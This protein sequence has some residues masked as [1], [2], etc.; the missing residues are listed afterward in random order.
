MDLAP[1]VKKLSDTSFQLEPVGIIGV[2]AKGFSWEVKSEKP[3]V[4]QCKNEMGKV[5]MVLRVLPPEIDFMIERL[6]SLQ[7]HQD[8]VV[9][10]LRAAGASFPGEQYDRADTTNYSDDRMPVARAYYLDFV[11]DDTPSKY[12]AVQFYRMRNSYMIEAAVAKEELESVLDVARQM[13]LQ[14]DSSKQ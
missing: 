2:P 12:F 1:S 7:K 14:C 9:K 4:F 6:D 10:R 13:K 3:L 5:K 8:Q 11:T